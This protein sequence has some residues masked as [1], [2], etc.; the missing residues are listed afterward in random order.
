VQTGRISRVLHLGYRKRIRAAGN[1]YGILVG[2]HK[3]DSE[4]VDTESEEVAQ[5]DE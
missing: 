5:E 2:N 1:L 3:V 4:V